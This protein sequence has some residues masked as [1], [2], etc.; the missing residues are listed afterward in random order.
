MYESRTFRDTGM[1]R[2]LWRT[3]TH[4]LALNE[5]PAPVG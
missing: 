2:D 3:A 5:I 4:S 1:K